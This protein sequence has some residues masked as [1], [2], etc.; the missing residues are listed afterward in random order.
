[1]VAATILKNHDI[2]TT[3]WQILMKFGMMMHLLP[4]RI[5]SAN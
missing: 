5:L 2:I 4:S 3:Y 1:M